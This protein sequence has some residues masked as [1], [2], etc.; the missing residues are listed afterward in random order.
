MPDFKGF[1]ESK[2]HQIPIPSSFFTELLTKI[3]AIGEMKVTLYVFWC[4]DR[5]EGPFKYLR[6][7]D[8][9]DDQTFFSSFGESPSDA[10]ASLEQSLMLSV[11]RGILL[12]A[13]TSTANGNETIYLLNSP[14]GRAA[15]H[16]IESGKWKPAPTRMG[17]SVT[18]ED[19]PNIFRL[20]EENIGMITPMIAEALA[21]AE[22]T[23]PLDWIEDAIRIA[24]QNNKRSWRYSQTI[25]ERWQREGKHGRKEKPEGRPDTEETRRRYVEGEFSDFIEH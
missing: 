19:V 22:Q 13:E 1:S 10:R 6:L 7:T 20:Y 15:L 16:A 24:V 3:E 17:A 11:E 5:M 18:S 4:L 2:S 12:T 23:Y 9:Y 8:F 14:R 25:L 21:D